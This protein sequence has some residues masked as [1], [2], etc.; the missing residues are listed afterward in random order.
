M[1]KTFKVDDRV[2]YYDQFKQRMMVGIVT[3]VH[4]NGQSLFVKDKKFEV[5]FTDCVKLKPK[6]QKV[7]RTRD[8]WI[9]VYEHYLTP[10]SNKEYADNHS[11]R[12]RLACIKKTLK[13]KD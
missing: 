7:I 6:K 5:Y 4:R 10:F 3:K 13:W 11:D 9:N 1:K 12:N 2:A 8:V